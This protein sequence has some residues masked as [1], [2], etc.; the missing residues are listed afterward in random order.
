MAKKKHFA[1]KKTRLAELPLTRVLAGHHEETAFPKTPA[2]PLAAAY[3][4]LVQE[5]TAL[6]SQLRPDPGAPPGNLSPPTLPPQPLS[7]P[8]H[9]KRV[10]KQARQDL[11]DLHLWLIRG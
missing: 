6:R 2:S 11:Q 10:L 7:D 9:L 8:R 3:F 5:L 4:A 1:G